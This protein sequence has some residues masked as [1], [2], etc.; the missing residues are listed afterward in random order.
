MRGFTSTEEGAGEVSY[1]LDGVEV[2]DP[3]T[4]SLGITLDKGAICQISLYPGWFPAEYDG[5]MSGIVNIT[6][7]DGTDRYKG[8]IEY[9][10]DGML[11]DGANR[12][13]Y[14]RIRFN[15]GGPLPTTFKSNFFLSGNLWD[16]DNWSPGILP[17]PHNDRAQR[18][19]F[20]KLGLRPLNNL[21]LTIGGNWAYEKFHSYNSG[22]SKHHS[23]VHRRSHGNWLKD[24]YLY[25]QGNSEMSFNLT[26]QPTANTFCTIDLA[27]FNTYTKR[28]AQDGK[29]YNDWEVIGR[30]LPWVGAAIDSGWYDPVWRRWNT[31]TEEE[32]WE[33][34][35]T[36][37]GYCYRDLITGELKWETVVYKQ[38]GLTPTATMMLTPGSSMQTGRTSSR[39]FLTS[40]PTWPMWLPVQSIK[41]ISIMATF[42]TGIITIRTSSTASVTTLS[43]AIT[44]GTLPTTRRMH[45]SPARLTSLIRSRLVYLIGR[46]TWSLRM[47]NFTM[48]FLIRITTKRSP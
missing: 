4:N 30:G 39:F 23:S 24:S 12:L 40:M 25:E 45:L 16:A 7:K 10:F 17:K 6:T 31:K 9:G 19:I 8:A 44:T 48:S 33:L 42:T 13:G 1:L 2:T 26:Y 27:R 32:P 21:R 47:F 5:A 15:L 41:V 28:S 36:D 22:G 14:N 46:I 29:H 35:Y 34:Y 18:D 20:A 38:I 3:F 37:L 11:K 43:P